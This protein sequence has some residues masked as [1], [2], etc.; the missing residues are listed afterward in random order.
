MLKE[1]MGWV[2]RGATWEALVA[3][4]ATPARRARTMDPPII[5]MVGDT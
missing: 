2:R 3:N 5:V 4:R 1:A